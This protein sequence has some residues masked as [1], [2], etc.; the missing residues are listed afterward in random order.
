MGRDCHW[1]HLR[2]G[3]LE[4]GRDPHPALWSLWVLAATLSVPALQKE[5]FQG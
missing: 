3:W 5:L 1:S 2:M 4:M